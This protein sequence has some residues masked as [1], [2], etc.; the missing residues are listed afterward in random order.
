L[1]QLALI[2]PEKILTEAN[3]PEP[4]GPY[5]WVTDFFSV[6]RSGATDFD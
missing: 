6:D 3:Y 2:A 5:P 1:H 4:T